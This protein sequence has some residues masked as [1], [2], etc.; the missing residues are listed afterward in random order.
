MAEN[1]EATG[2]TF[3]MRKFTNFIDKFPSDVIDRTLQ[4][5]SN[6]LSAEMAKEA[7][8]DHGRLASSISR[9]QRIGPLSWGI[10]IGA[11]Y[12]RPV[13]FGK[14]PKSTY[15]YPKTAKVLRFK[16]EGQYVFARKVRNVSIPANP[17][18][19][20][21]IDTTTGRLKDFVGRAISELRGAA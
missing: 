10:K 9:G 8:V 1:I 19:D 17:F 21:A 7:P 13:Q 12:W 16:I 3:D 20:R 5:V 18:I 14:K 6:F 15:I 11:K 2:I 4:Y